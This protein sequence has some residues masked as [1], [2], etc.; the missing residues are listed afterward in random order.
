MWNR[1]R[2]LVSS[3][4]VMILKREYFHRVKYASSRILGSKRFDKA[5]LLECLYIRIAYP[6]K[7]RYLYKFRYIYIYIPK[8]RS[9]FLKDKVI[10]TELLSF[11]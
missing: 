6:N 5:N 7:S 10:N 4:M 8:P 1:D 9:L 3:G 2:K 11:H